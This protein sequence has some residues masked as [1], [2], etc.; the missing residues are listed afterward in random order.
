[1][2]HARALITL[3]NPEAQISLSRQIIKKQLSVREVEKLVS[4]QDRIPKE[5]KKTPPDPNLL[6]L[7]EEILQLLGTKVSISGN[8]N[9]GIVKIYYFSVD[10]LNSIFDKIKGE[11]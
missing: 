9:K 4:Q 8:Q 7:Q 10:E 6:A 5:K 3:E 2:G 1:M 11:N